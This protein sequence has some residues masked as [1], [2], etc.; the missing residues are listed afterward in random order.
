MVAGFRY[1]VPVR[2][3]RQKNERVLLGIRDALVYFL[4]PVAI[5]SRV[6]KIWNT[7]LPNN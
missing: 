2:E 4:F 1:C 5:N 7:F 6:E 3:L